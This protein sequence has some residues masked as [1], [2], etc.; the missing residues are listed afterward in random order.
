MDGYV[1]PYMQWGT[2]QEPF[3]RAAYELK[4]GADIDQVGFV[5]HDTIMRMGGSPDGLVDDDGIIEIKA[6]KTSTHISWMLDGSVPAEHEP[7]MS[8]YLSC[9]GRKWADFISFD[10]RLP[11]P[12]QLFVKRLQRNE[13]RIAEIEAAV[14]QFHIEV[15]GTIDRLREICGDFTI[16]AQM[17]EAPNLPED[18]FLTEADFEGLL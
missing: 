14:K 16:P 15:D 8:F 7:Q 6:P 1:S 18:G 10:P 17:I 11:E 12:L 3:A 5:S 4:T 9:T 2:D 13:E